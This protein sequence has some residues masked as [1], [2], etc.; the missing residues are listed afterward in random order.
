MNIPFVGFALFALGLYGVLT[1]RDVLRVLIG[2]MLMLASITLLAVALSRGA[3]G[4]ALVLFAWVVEIVEI[5]VG[6]AI[7]LY[8]NAKGTTSIRDLRELKW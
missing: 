1:R 4:Q 7:F 3:V 5:L 2:A 8:L 6:L